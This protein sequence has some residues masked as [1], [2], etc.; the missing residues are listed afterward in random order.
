MYFSVVIGF[1]MFDYILFNVLLIA[2]SIDA[3]LGILIASGIEALAKFFVVR[4][5]MNTGSEAVQDRPPN[6]SE[7]T[8]QTP[9]E[10][11]GVYRA[12][13]T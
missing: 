13:A 6:G 12:K 2:F 8:G 5:A 10:R 11:S 1:K 7:T 4:K 9:C 3:P